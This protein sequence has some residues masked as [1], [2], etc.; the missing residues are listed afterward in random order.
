MT[1][2]APPSGDPADD[3]SLAGVLRASFKKFL[4]QTDG[5]LPA[6]VIAFDRTKNRA[7]VAP[8]VT[9]LTTDGRVVQRAQIA[10][11]PVVQ[12]GGGGV[13]LNFNLKA[14]DFG[15]IEANDRDISTFLQSYKTSPPNTFRLHSFQDAV[16]VP[17]VMRGWAIAGEDADNA[18]LQTLDGNAKV[19]VGASH[20]KLVFGGASLTLD[21]SGIAAAFGGHS[22]T[23]N[24]GGVT[25]VGPTT[26]S[27]GVTGGG[28]MTLSGGLT[29]DGLNVGDHTHTD[30][31]GGNVG[32][33]HN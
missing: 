14:G 20:V 32:A 31:Q 17:D 6:V 19:A 7:T 5:R 26:M 21:A 11:V 24:G 10:S 29:V 2:F 13:V 9:A 1:D 18:V 28:G 8:C 12:V 23:I 27:G 22:V 25:I 33:P 3:D 30:P 15:W 16:F 4:Q